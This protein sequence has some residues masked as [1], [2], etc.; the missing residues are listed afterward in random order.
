MLIS[1]FV[2]GTMN[3]ARAAFLMWKAHAVAPVYINKE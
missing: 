1:K 2:W 3:P